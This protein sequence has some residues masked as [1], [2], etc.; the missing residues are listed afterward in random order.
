MIDWRHWHNEPYLIGGLIF[1]GWLYAILAGPLRVRL[2]P[3]VGYPRAQA[4]KFYSALVIF[5][6]AVGSPLDQIGERFLFSAHMLQ[7]QLL[8]YPAAIFFLLGLPAWMIDPVLGRR[9]LR[10]LVRFI[11]HPVVA[12][13]IYVLVLSIWHFPS[14][15]D[16]ALRD[17]VV[18]VIEHVMFFG[19]GLI[20]WWP[21]LSPSKV[22]PPISFGSQMLYQFGVI[23]GLTPLFAYVTFMTDILYPT[24]EYAPRLFADF[25][26]ANDQLLSGVMMKM[27]SIMVG[28]AAI[29]TSFYRWYQ[30]VEQGSATKP[31]P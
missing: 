8:V 13:L 1:L 14:L 4:I 22:A 7:H 27:M 23:I 20:Y 31:R 11:V 19:A 26:A 15:Y 3:G 12:G 30:A 21:Q 6:L 9:G 16:W 2:A 10:P 28:V 5:Y 18:H 24:Y 25:S 29:G 17:K